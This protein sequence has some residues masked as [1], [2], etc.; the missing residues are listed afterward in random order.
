MTDWKQCIRMILAAA[1]TAVLPMYASARMMDGAFLESASTVGRGAWNLRSVLEY[2]SK[3]KPMITNVS[4]ANVELKVGYV[5]FPIEIRYGLNDRW[6]I[7]GDA[8]FELD[9]GGV[10]VTGGG[11]FLNGNGLRR[12]RLFGKWNFMPDMAAMADLAF[13]GDNTLYNSLDSFDFGLKFLYGPQI[14]GGALNLNLGFLFKS[15]DVNLGKTFQVD[16]KSVISYGIGYVRPFSNRFTGIVELAGATSPYKGKVGVSSTTGR[17]DLLFG[18]R[19]AMSDRMNLEGALGKGFQ[20]GS[21]SFTLRGGIDIMWGQVSKRAASSDRWTPKDA[22]QSEQKPAAGTATQATKPAEEKPSGPVFEPPA[23]YE[24]PKPPSQAPPAGPTVEE[25]VQK[26][27]ADASD[28]FNRGDYASA[29]T[30]YEA[31][32]KL[33]DNDPLLH[34]NLATAYFQQ[35]KYADAKKYFKNAMLLNPVDAD[36]HLYL[37]YTYYYLQDQAGAI[38]EWQKVLEIDPSNETARENLKALGVE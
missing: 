27:I 18:G 16:Y 25:R 6:E 12:L 31:A 26:S 11:S 32:I 35:K 7:G 1:M 21:P 20:K 33:K 24:T 28:A 10:N 9:K 2:G 13:A 14:G 23:Q 37:G 17:L 29:A 38:R 22:K 15:G 8:G 19:L 36:S 5:L 4:G 30:N 3:A 34:Y